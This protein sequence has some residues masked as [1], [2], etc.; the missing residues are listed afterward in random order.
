MDQFTKLLPGGKSVACLD[1]L[2]PL[3]VNELKKTFFTY[4]E[5]LSGNKDDLVL[6]TYAVF[7]RARDGS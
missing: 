5:N 7:S 3:K 4:H 2:V 6:R 1:D